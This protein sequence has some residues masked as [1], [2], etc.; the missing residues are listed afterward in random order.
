MAFDG[1]GTFLRLRSWIADATAGVKVRADF[2]DDEDN[3]FADG[4]SH[5]ITKDGQTTVTQNIP[6]NSKRVTAL[7]DPVDPQDA[8][9]KAYADTKASLAGGSTFTGDVTI[10]NDDPTFTLNGKDGFNNAIWGQKNGKNR[11]ALLLGD[12]TAE[13]G[14]NAGSNFELINFA[15][16]GT[17]LGPALFGTRSTSLLTVKGDPT[18][19]LGISTKQY[20]DSK[21][22]LAGGSITGNLQ[23]NGE[24]I[25]V[26]N[27]LRFG[28]SGGPGYIMWNGGANYS[29]GG[30]GTIWHSGNFNPNASILVSNA[31]MV[32]VGQPALGTSP[33]WY[34]PFNGGFVTGWFVSQYINLQ[35]YLGAFIVRNLQLYTTSWWTVLYA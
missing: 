12:S 29:L 3:N 28:A 4:L 17:Q 20:A 15:D 32:I 9:T 13:S 31:R 10:N 2:H 18:A 6:F 34:E 26:Q 11:W 19:A 33:A 8:A 22:P 16:D 24:L 23:V 35:P 1:F 7:A 21:L 14:G 25:A 5:C 27:Y 30:G